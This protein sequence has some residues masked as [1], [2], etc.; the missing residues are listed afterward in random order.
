M[1]LSNRVITPTE[2][3]YLAANGFVI[4]RK[5]PRLTLSKFI[6]HRK[7]EE[8]ILGGYDYQVPP[9]GDT[10]A[11][12]CKDCNNC[13]ITGLADGKTFTPFSHWCFL[14]CAKVEADGGCSKGRGAWGPVI[15]VLNGRAD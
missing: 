12:R 3:P 7:R 5:R 4:F 6:R 11:T 15:Q 8:Q 13:I 9:P 2:Y 10:Q 1:K 14:A